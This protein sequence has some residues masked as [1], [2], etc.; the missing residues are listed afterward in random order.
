MRVGAQGENLD[1]VF[2]VLFFCI[3]QFTISK[4]VHVGPTGGFHWY[5]G[6]VLGFDVSI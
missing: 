6:R 1:M 3:W 2:M 4:S 5:I